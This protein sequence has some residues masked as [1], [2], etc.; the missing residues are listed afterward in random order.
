MSQLDPMDLFLGIAGALALQSL[1]LFVVI[2]MATKA[3]KRA[4]Y[5]WAQ[6]QFL[7]FLA[8]EKGM[9]EQEVNEI[10]DKL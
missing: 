10:M 7:A 3:D 9:S 1:I 8:K 5:G 2:N 4:K 6:T